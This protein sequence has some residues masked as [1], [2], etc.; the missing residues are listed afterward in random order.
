MKKLLH[1]TDTHLNFLSD[2][3]VRVFAEDVQARV[4]L[5]EAICVIITGDLSSA[6]W[7]KRNLAILRAH[8]KVPVYFVRGNHDF[9]HGAISDSFSE[10]GY[11]Q[12]IPYVKLSE[13]TA[14]CGADGWYDSLYS[15]MND[16]EVFLSD[17]RYIAEL[18]DIVTKHGLKTVQMK[19]YLQSLA[20]KH[21]AK[22]KESVALI[23][24]ETECKH[25]LVATHVPP[26]AESSRAP[27]GSQ[28]DKDFLPYFSSKI[29]GK[30]LRELASEHTGHRFT[31]YCGH[32]HTEHYFHAA[33]RLECYV[34][35]AKYGTPMGS[36]RVVDV[37]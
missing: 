2:N 28:S 31:V 9:Y 33:D 17:F 25:I 23:V 18:N 10:T 35:Y 3:P 36:M 1:L 15:D 34:G 21:A 11:L 14:L 4:R 5:E 24:K 20:R 13:E 7:L 22:I 27:D 12:D 37:A 19:T 6:E 32:T 8:I 26:F 16:S 29:M 30:A